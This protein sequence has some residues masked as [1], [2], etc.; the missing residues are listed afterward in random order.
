MASP[1]TRSRATCRSVSLPL[2]ICPNYTFV[3]ANYAQLAYLSTILL[4]VSVLSSY[5]VP[6]FFELVGGF[7]KYR[8]HTRRPNST[9]VQ[10]SSTSA[11]PPA[12]QF[13]VVG[14]I[15]VP[16]A[17]YAAAA[18]AAAQPPVQQLTGDASGGTNTVYAPVAT[19]PS[20]GPPQ[21]Q[22]QQLVKKQPSRCSDGRRSGSAGDA[23][24]ASLAVSSSSQTT[25]A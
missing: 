8:L 19:L 6:F 23:S 25:S 12:P 2:L 13:V 20:S 4:T 9:A 3:D 24:S 14:G 18:A 11:A 10:S 1:T 15:W 5:T 16:P 22:S 7:Q 17:E 21:T